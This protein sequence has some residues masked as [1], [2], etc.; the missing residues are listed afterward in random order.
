MEPEDKLVARWLDPL[1]TNLGDIAEVF[2]ETRRRTVIEWR[3]G[4]AGEPRV[5]FEAGTSA[6]LKRSGREKLAF[7]SGADE[8]AIR[9]AIRGLQASAAGA[10]SPA[11][12]STA[13]PEGAPDPTAERWVRRF[14]GILQRH[15]PRHRLRWTLEDVSRRVVPSGLPAAAWVRRL[16]SLEG[17]FVAAS[18][19]GDET[20]GFSFHAPEADST[21]DEL[22]QALTSAAAPRERP[23]PFGS[24]SAD[25][26]LSS[27]TAAI[28]FHEI[29]SHALEADAEESPL[30]RLTAARLSVSDL[31]VR[32]DPT[33]LDLFG[34]YESDDEGSRPRPV[35]LL[36]AGRLAGKLLDRAHGGPRGSTGHGRRAGPGDAP[37]P[38]GSNTVVSAGGA[39]TEE[40]TRRLGNGLWIDEIESGTVELSSGTFRL[41]Y[42]RARRV[43]RGR[44]ADEVGAGLLAG[45]ILP[46]L[47]A[48]E[49]M[50]GH[51]VRSCRSLAWCSRA[52][53]V[54]AVGGAAPDVIVRRLS[55]RDR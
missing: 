2:I 18:R 27:G 36:D 17:T 15:A 23:A 39:T 19:R 5:S 45:E 7:V 34:G 1:V 14:P 44:F 10:P 8:L 40:M 49:P 6:R 28:L 42:P 26:L 35:K 52:G 30:S 25:V 9:E 37:L 11:R 31:E 38:R 29:L 33:R 22:K 16:F 4:Q 32:D 50:I 24:A 53:Q 20:R 3:D 55:V 54:V 13:R 12:T 48:I 47:E 21:A 41:R 51:E 43:R 46:A